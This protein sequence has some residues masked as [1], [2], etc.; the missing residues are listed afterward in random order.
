VNFMN[1]TKAPES[2]EVKKPK[3]VANP[4]AATK[5]KVAAYRVG[6]RPTIND[7][8]ADEFSTGKVLGYMRG[9][10]RV[11]W[12]NGNVISTT[13]V[14]EASDKSKW[15]IGGQYYS[16][17]VSLGEDYIQYYHY[18]ECCYVRV[19]EFCTMDSIARRGLN[20][21]DFH[22]LFNPDGNGVCEQAHKIFPGIGTRKVDLYDAD[23]N[24]EEDDDEEPSVRDADLSRKASGGKH[25]VPINSAACGLRDGK[26]WNLNG[27]PITYFREL[28]MQVN[29]SKGKG[30]SYTQTSEWLASIHPKVNLVEVTRASWTKIPRLELEEVRRLVALHGCKSDATGFFP[31]QSMVDKWCFMNRYNDEYAWNLL[32]VRSVTQSNYLMVDCKYRAGPADWSTQ[33]Q[34]WVQKN[35]GGDNEISRVARLRSKKG[36][37]VDKKLVL[38]NVLLNT[39]DPL[40]QEYRGVR[41]VHVNDVLLVDCGVDARVQQILS[42]LPSDPTKLANMIVCKI[43]PQMATLSK[44]NAIA[45]DS[46]RRTLV[47]LEVEQARLETS[48]QMMNR[49]QRTILDD[50]VNSFAQGNDEVLIT[51]SGLMVTTRDVYA[52]DRNYAKMKPKYVGKYEVSI[53]LVSPGISVRNIQAPLLTG[54]GPNAKRRVHP[55][56]TGNSQSY[57]C[58]GDHKDML[59]SSMQ[60]GDYLMVM[61]VV[62]EL[63]ASG[64]YSELKHYPVD[65]PAPELLTVVDQDLVF[66]GE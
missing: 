4:K 17:K 46:M 37:G 35:G 49:D 58:L 57:M 31:N 38:L 16:Y 45:L 59:I 23:G 25:Y 64:W 22:Q 6:V 29:I 52:D 15:R 42:K 55:N 5:P 36:N 60:A 2:K 43:L 48:L 28:L 41:Y 7:P 50:I 54:V 20:I 32:Q 21:S 61:R 47:K 10:T 13:N 33:A 53:N 40:L 8:I 56:T 19:Q 65:K 24:F 66:F 9:R 12:P 44:E 27:K 34:E 14:S 51:S 39:S 11:Q 30:T 62:Y 1:I 18:G 63:L 3:A 26:A